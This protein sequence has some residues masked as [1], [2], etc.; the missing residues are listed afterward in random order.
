MVLSITVGALTREFAVYFP[1]GWEHYVQQIPNGEGLPLLVAIHGGGQSYE[2]FLANWN[3]VLLQNQ[4]NIVATLGFATEWDP[5]GEPARYWRAWAQLSP[6]TDVDD[7]LFV[8]SAIDKVAA[9]ISQ[10]YSVL[11]I[12]NRTT[13]DAKRR[14]LF[15]YSNGAMMA[16]RLANSTQ[17]A[18]ATGRPS[19]R[20]RGRSAA[21]GTRTRTRWST[22]RAR[23]SAPR[24]CPC[25]VTTATSIGPS[26]RGCRPTP[27]PWCAANSSWTRS[28]GPA[29]ST[30]T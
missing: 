13:I 29:R 15:G 22:A 3:F 2:T 20:S 8:K 1:V 19:G 4:D 28:S 11:G 24:A 30:G 7:P 5:A 16:Y 21:G 12:A 10:T 26:R 18:R 17:F 14:F 25:S 9:L 6:N 27:A 23:P